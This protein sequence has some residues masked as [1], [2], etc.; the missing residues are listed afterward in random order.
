MWHQRPNFYTFCPSVRTFI[1]PSVSYPLLFSV[2]TVRFSNFFCLKGMTSET[3]LLYFLSVCLSVRPS[4]CPYP[5]S[6]LFLPPDFQNS[7]FVWKVWHQ[8]H[9]FY[10]FCP[11]VHPFICPYPFSISFLPFD[12][13]NS[14]LFERYQTH[15]RDLALYFLSVCPCVYLSGRSVLLFQFP[16]RTPPPPF[17][18]PF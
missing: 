17:Q 16:V 2:L 10:N 9:N 14:F 7:F 15:I 11:S 8:R 5:F 13:Q 12:F 6:I 4:V 1:R 3:F 18:F